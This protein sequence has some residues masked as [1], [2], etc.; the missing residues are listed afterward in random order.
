MIAF[1][2]KSC[3]KTFDRP[4]E[5]AG[6]LIFCTCGQAN[7][8]PW[9]SSVALPAEA[10]RPR[11]GLPAAEEREDK[12]WPPPSRQRQREFPDPD[13]SRCLNHDDESS[14]ETCAD[15]DEAFCAACV[16]TLQGRT[17][18][19]PCKNL[20]LRRLQRP[21]RPSLLAVFSLVVALAGGAAG[22]VV[23]SAATGMGS[24]EL[25]YVSLAP[26][27][28]AFVLGFAA[29]RKI[30]NDPHVS[31][32]AVAICGLVSAVVCGILLALFAVLMVGTLE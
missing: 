10:P 22:F 31:G 2:C 16:V 21:P 17:L 24:P 15:C 28:V 9:E 7:R 32:R 18:C 8:V 25:G 4:D 1:A 11:R 13:P 27:L 19:G 30:E 26:Q 6:S 12:G 23:L 14:Q 29:L 3:G 20:R 5:E